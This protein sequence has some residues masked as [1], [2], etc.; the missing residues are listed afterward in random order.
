MSTISS[1]QRRRRGAI[2]PLYILAFLVMVLALL[3][4]APFN[5]KTYDSFSTVSESSG[6]ASVSLSLTRKASFASDLQYWNANCSH[7]WTPGSPCQDIVAKTKSCAT[8]VNSAYCS[9]YDS[10]LQQFRN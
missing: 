8:S 4:S 3:V 7:G 2:D 1:N 6:D 5:D 10:Y 9:E